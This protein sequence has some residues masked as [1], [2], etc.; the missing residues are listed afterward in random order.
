[1]LCYLLQV[2]RLFLEFPEAVKERSTEISDAVVERSK[3]TSLHSGILAGAVMMTAVGVVVYL[4][5]AKQ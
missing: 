1:M 5:H 4:R 3:L 2:I